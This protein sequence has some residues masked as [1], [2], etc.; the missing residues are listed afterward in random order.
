VTRSHGH[1]FGLVAAAITACV[2]GCAPRCPATPGGHPR[3]AA[4]N[5]CV[6]GARSGQAEDYSASLVVV[7]PEQFA[8]KR[9]R[10][11]GV[12]TTT[13]D[14]GANFYASRWDRDFWGGWERVPSVQ[15]TARAVRPGLGWSMRDV[16]AAC[17]RLDVVIEATVRATPPGAARLVPT[18]DGLFDITHVEEQTGVPLRWQDGALDK[19]LAPPLLGPASQSP[20]GG[21]APGRKE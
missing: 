3:A 19:L 16:V 4:R 14:G 6:F 18:D 2:V 10:V 15:V 8:G 1:A 17:A 12:L 9:V 11:R 13:T 7:Q 20:Q 21:T 5:T